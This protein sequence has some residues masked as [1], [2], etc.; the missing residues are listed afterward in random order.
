MGT[1][2]VHVLFD[3]ALQDLLLAKWCCRDCARGPHR[4]GAFL[5]RWISM[6]R[7]VPCQGP[8]RVR[9]DQSGDPL[10]ILRLFIVVIFTLVQKIDKSNPGCFG[11]NEAKYGG[12]G[13][14]GDVVVAARA[15]EEGT[16]D[17]D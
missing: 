12:V 1:R 2:F 9:R 14:P 13:A 11:Q 15:G 7:R 16:E 5:F 17:E 6:L 4:T 8:L 10:C 3:S